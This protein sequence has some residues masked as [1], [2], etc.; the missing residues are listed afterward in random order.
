MAMQWDKRQLRKTKPTTSNEIQ[1]LNKQQ[2]NKE[3]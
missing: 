1:S 2:E 3:L